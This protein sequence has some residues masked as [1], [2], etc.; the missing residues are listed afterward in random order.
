MAGTSVG[1]VNPFPFLGGA[2]Y[3]PVLGWVLDLY[4]KMADGA[5]SIGAYSKLLLILLGTA[6]LALICTFL[7][8]ETYA[9]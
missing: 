7:M 9:E 6:F 3:M 2:I 5:Y 4:P 8:K 1:A